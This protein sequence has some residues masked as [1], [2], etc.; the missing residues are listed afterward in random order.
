MLCSE[1]VEGTVCRSC[2][3]PFTAVKNYIIFSRFLCLFS[4]HL[5]TKLNVIN[6]SNLCFYI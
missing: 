2:R 5:A 4:L 3:I 6:N 1:G